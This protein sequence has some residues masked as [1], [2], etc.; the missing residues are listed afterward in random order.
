M[1][2]YES[3]LFL[4]RDGCISRKRNLDAVRNHEIEQDERKEMEEVIKK[5]RSAPDPDLPR[6]VTPPHVIMEGNLVTTC[7]NITLDL[8]SSTHRA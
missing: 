3:Y 6:W 5:M 2:A 8:R 4:C 1:L 7:Y